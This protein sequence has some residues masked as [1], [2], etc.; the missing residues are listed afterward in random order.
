M[1][2]NG[3]GS[4]LYSFTFTSLETV[5]PKVISTYPANGTIR[6]PANKNITVTFNEIIGEGDTFGDII[7]KAGEDII[8]HAKSITGKIHTLTIPASAL[9]DTAGNLSLAYTLYFTTIQDTA[10][11]P[12]PTVIR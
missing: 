3:A 5:A 6:I 9:K 1:D 12:S 10:V 4:G 8:P 11:L 2:V 7:V